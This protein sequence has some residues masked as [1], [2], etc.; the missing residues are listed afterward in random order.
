MI[1]GSPGA[2]CARCDPAGFSSPRAEDPRSADE[3]LGPGCLWETALRLVEQDDAQ[4]QRCMYMTQ[5]Q[6]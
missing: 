5:K 1:F 6:T 3:V 2:E 4:T